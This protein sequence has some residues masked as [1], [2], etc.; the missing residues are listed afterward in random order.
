[1]QEDMPVSETSSS[2]GGLY[3]TVLAL[4]GSSLS[5]LPAAGGRRQWLLRLGVGDVR[6][7]GKVLYWWEGINRLR[8]R[9]WDCDAMGP[10]GRVWGV[11]DRRG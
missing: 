4:L 3:R 1:M 11:G 7:R 6:L 10:A 8:L 5:G 9:L 2:A